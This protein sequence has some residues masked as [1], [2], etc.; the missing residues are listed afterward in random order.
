MR[1][2]LQR[3][4]TLDRGFG[5]LY[6][7][8]TSDRFFLHLIII[9]VVAAFI[10][11]VIL[12]SGVFSVGSAVPGG[13]VTEGLVGTPR[14]V[15]PVLAT[16]RADRD[17]SALVY[18]GLMK[19]G[20][21]G[22][23]VPDLA[24][25]VTVSDD[26]RTYNVKLK[27]GLTFH[28]GSSLTASDVSY[29]IALIQNPD[30]KSPLRS[31]WYGV[32]VEEVNEHE[33]NIVLEEPYQSFQE[34][35]TVGI[36]PR[37]QWQDLPPEQLFF[38]QHNTEPI[39]A[40]PYKVTDIERDQAGLISSYTLRAFI[41][42]DPTP[43]I[44]EIEVR[45]FRNE[46]ELFQ[47]IQADEISSSPSLQTNQLASLD[48]EYRVYE[49]SL[50]RTFAV[51]FNQNRSPILR[52][53]SAR[54]ALSQAIDRHGITQEVLDGYGTPINSPLPPQFIASSSS[55]SSSSDAIAA[56]TQTLRDGDW[57]KNDDGIWQKT[58]DGD[59][60]PLQFTIT[61]ANSDVFDRTATVVAEQWQELGAD[62]SVA[63]YSQGDLVQ[64]IVRP[65]D[66][67]VLLFGTDVGR[68]VDLYS[69]W[70]SSQKDDPGLNVAQFTN[71]D[72]DALL[73][74]LQTEQ[75]QDTRQDTYLELSELISSE[76][77][78][79]FLFSPVFPYVAHESISISPL[80]H[81]GEPSERFMNISSWYTETHRVWPLFTSD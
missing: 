8:R 48:E 4:S 10:Y 70:H 26:G 7:R 68:A 20:P 71:I 80:S 65:R 1:H 29:T 12:I 64:A 21:D 39:G 62:V 56:A 17:V 43:K 69:F 11:G 35:L 63:Q 52:D 25:S 23:L 75:D 46:G 55:A 51:F 78:A 3:R 49:Y 22:T 74:D 57:S 45:F 5:F 76:Y 38:S 47:A 6:R 61:T 42:Y 24:E 60:V 66:F 27:E 2:P 79:A 28:D 14:F 9:G 44:T 58:I 18:R 30:I 31:D 37:E 13:T 54:Q 72:A 32:L 33:L 34:N 15:N 77:P 16:T 67:D 41:G 53:S 40:G 59:T 36:L 50:P 73:E 19:I 81:I